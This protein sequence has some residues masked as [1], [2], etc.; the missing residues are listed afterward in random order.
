MDYYSLIPANR[1]RDL[2]EIACEGSA[3][4]RKHKVH[5]HHAGIATL[6]E[7]YKERMKELFPGRFKKIRLFVLD[8]YDLILSK[9]SRNIDRDGDEVKTEETKSVL[10]ALRGSILIMGAANLMIPLAHGSVV[11]AMA[12]LRLA[13]VGDVCWPVFDVCELS[14]RQ[15]ITTGEV[16]GR[17]N[18][19]CRCQIAASC[20]VGP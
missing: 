18:G 15:A 13:Q 12:F 14:L 5:L 4:A 8:P 17:V 11:T 1:V 10:I 20:P 2:E 19:R 16:L 3:L 9:L 7:N 6:P